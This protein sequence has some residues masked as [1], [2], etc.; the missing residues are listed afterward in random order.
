MQKIALSLAP[1]NLIIYRIGLQV[2]KQQNSLLLKLIIFQL[3]TPLT[4]GPQN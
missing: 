4:E 1:P 2:L 3:F